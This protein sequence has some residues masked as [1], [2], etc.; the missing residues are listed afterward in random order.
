MLIGSKLDR[1]NRPLSQLCQQSKLTI[2][3]KVFWLNFGRFLPWF[4]SRAKIPNVNNIVIW[5]HI[6]LNL[7]HGNKFQG[8]LAASFSSIVNSAENLLSKVS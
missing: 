3:L 8:E 4:L 5:R 1:V 6:F 7:N 2:P